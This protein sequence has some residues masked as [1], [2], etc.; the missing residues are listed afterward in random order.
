MAGNRKIT[1]EFLGD[2]KD[3][4]N[5]LGDVD[6]KSSKL[7]STLGK[8]GKAAALGLGAGLVVGG[9]ALVKMTQGAIED[10]AAQAKLAKQLKN[11]ADATKGQIAAT[12]EWIS[13]QGVALGVTDDELRPALS[14]LVTA[15]GDVGEAQ[16][17]AALAMD[18]SAGSGKSLEAVSLALMKA[19]N[20]EIGGLSKLGIATKNAA[21][22]TMTFEQVTKN[23]ADTF[24]GQAATQAN[25]LEGKMAKLKLIMA[26]A[27][28]TI[29]SKVIPI[30]TDL[31]DWFMAKG[32]PAI[33]SFG[34][35]VATKLGPPLEKVGG[36]IKDTLVPAVKT[37]VSQ[38][39]DGEG[40]GGKFADVFG[41]VADVLGKVA[42]FISEN[43]TAVAT[44]V[45]IIGAA[46]A[47]TKAWAIV[48]G[49]LN[50]VL[51]ANPLGL[52]V[53]AIAAVAAGLVIAYK[54]SET[55]RAIVD[56]A[57][58]AVGKTGRWL[59]ENALKPAFEGIKK[60]FEAVGE[61]GKWLWNNA[62]QPA[63][64]FIVSGIASILDMWSSM[65]SALAKV[66]GFGWA[67]DA[68]DAMGKAAIKARE[69]ADGIN[70]IPDSKTI[71][72]TTVY[73]TRNKAKENFNS[74]GGGDDF[75]GRTSGRIAGGVS[76]GFLDG[77]MKQ[78]LEPAGKALLTGL[79]SGIE[80]K[81]TKLQTVLEKITDEIK[82]RQ[83][84]LATLLDKRQS[85]VDSFKGFA[86]SVFGADMGDAENP[87][88]A[89]TLVDH[90]GGQ[91]AKAE[92]L[93]A[94]VK[95]LIDKGM[96]KD[97]I[98][99]LIA[100]GQSGMD[101]IHLLAGA[102]NEQIAALNANQAATQAA[103]AAAGLAAADAVIGEQI[104]AAQRDVALADGIRDKLQALLEQQDK[105]TVVQLILDGK[106]LHASLMKL[107]KNKGKKLELD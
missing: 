13:A 32:L 3:L 80:K 97:L 95:A 31:A 81:K 104:A 87:A 54:R 41:T 64:K 28:E 67:K 35:M 71:N 98:N 89:Q 91:R 16:K 51:S 24:G 45:G 93:S 22:E 44:F 42:E 57:L 78:L 75:L 1:I 11:S 36:W 33:Q 88:T 62:L 74:R 60:G 102:T 65:L 43:K 34:D 84:K 17:L 100:S 5:A 105:N 2:S 12:E 15:T 23:M 7:S 53:I 69:F 27:G 77:K 107:K 52:V 68:A 46:V 21:G 72:I 83:D 76:K 82:K 30:V 103:L 70:K 25:T 79:I 90:S 99:E 92:T 39:Q 94:D 19:R 38:I 20:G 55:F 66:P 85:I 86:T 4:Q 73:T 29:G 14:K 26:E 49:V 10:E 8:V 101:Q 6:G 9:A 61:A 63:F 40:A 18:V 48:Q 56:A 47:I 106:T 59:W 37:F 96:S 50:A 58:E